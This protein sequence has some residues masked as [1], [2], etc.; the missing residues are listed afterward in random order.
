MSLFQD[1]NLIL[2]I[3]LILRVLKYNQMTSLRLKFPQAADLTSIF[4]A[5]QNI[6]RGNSIEAIK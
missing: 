1:S 6:S 3:S 4:N 5:E 2:S